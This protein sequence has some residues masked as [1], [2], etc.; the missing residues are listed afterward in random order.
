VPTGADIS[1]SVTVESYLSALSHHDIA[2]AKKLVYPK[3]RKNIMDASGSGFTDLTNLQDVKVLATATGA[4]YR[5]SEPGVSFSKYGEFAQVTVSYSATF[6][7]SKEPSG[8]QRKL[9]TVGKNSSSKWVILA[10]DSST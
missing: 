3:V 2:L 9:M 1:P 8:L 4:Q 6:S 7:S 10:V 5:P